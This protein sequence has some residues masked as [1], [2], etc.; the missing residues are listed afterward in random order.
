MKV[1]NGWH[2]GTLASL[3]VCVM[4]GHMVKF[5][6]P[7][8]GTKKLESKKLPRCGIHHEAFNMSFKDTYG[9]LTPRAE[10]GSAANMC[11]CRAHD[12]PVFFVRRDP[13][14]QFC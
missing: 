7:C 14:V 10:V 11:A 12:A 4:Y 2:G 13:H 9:L 6:V 8:E 3:R 5:C 1:Q